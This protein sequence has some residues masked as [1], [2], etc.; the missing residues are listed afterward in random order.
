MFAPFPK[1]PVSW[2]DINL[3]NI[4]VVSNILLFFLFFFEVDDSVIKSKLFTPQVSEWTSRY[5][6]KYLI[7]NDNIEYYKKLMIQYDMNNK[8]H[9]QIL[10]VNALRDK[11]FFDQ[12]KYIKFDLDEIRWSEWKNLIDDYRISFQDQYLF[13]LGLSHGNKS[14]LSWVTYQFSHMN[15]WHLISNMIFIVLIGY[16]IEGLLGPVGFLLL[17]IFSGI[18]GGLFYLFF[19]PFTLIPMVGA[20]GAVSGLISFYTFYYFRKP[21]RFLYF[22]GVQ[23][24]QFGF[25]YLPTWIIF[26]MFLVPDLA[27]FFSQINGVSAGIAFSAHIGGALFGGLS[28]LLVKRTIPEL[29]YFVT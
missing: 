15:L 4:I 26:P 29:E 17:Y 2:K 11:S 23:T 25:I 7:Q 19:N 14:S 1:T 24:N 10:S 16:C 22:F 27:S 21:T 9:R 8:I 13:Q 20:S 6:Y 3:T 12:I 5:Y 28:A 18:A